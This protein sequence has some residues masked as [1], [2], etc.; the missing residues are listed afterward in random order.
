MSKDN[1]ARR[2]E[3]YQVEQLDDVRTRLAHLEGRATGFATTES[4][5]HLETRMT[6]WA[7]GLWVGGFIVAINLIISVFIA[8]HRLLS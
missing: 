7:V 5:A 6:R 1:G 2:F 4:V 8:V 3:S